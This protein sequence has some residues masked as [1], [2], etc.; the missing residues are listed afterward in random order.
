MDKLKPYG[1]SVI[2]CV[3]CESTTRM[4]GMYPSG[5]PGAGDG[6]RLKCNDAACQ[7]EWLIYEQPLPNQKS[8]TIQKRI[9]LTV[10]PK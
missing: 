5:V 10:P 6:V 1:P 2:R 3:L 7:T 9:V 8:K 4:C